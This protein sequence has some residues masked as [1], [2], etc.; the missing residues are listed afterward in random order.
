MG[1]VYILPSSFRNHTWGTLPGLS[2]VGTAPLTTVLLRPDSKAPKKDF[3]RTEC[4]TLKPLLNKLHQSLVFGGFSGGFWGTLCRVK[5]P[6]TLPRVLV[7]AWERR[8]LVSGGG[9]PR[10]VKSVDLGTVLELPKTD[11]YYVKCGTANS[12]RTH[13]Q[14]PCPTSLVLMLPFT[15][16]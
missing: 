15:P 11:N 5:P 9:C 14:P 12:V 7:W 13:L 6:V 16:L 3:Y 2:I 8:F 10:A 1:Y 4:T